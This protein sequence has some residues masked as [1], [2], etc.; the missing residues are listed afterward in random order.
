METN[1]EGIRDRLLSRL[2]QPANLAEYGSQVAALLAKNEKGLRRETWG[3][4]ATWIFAVLLGTAF[5]LG[6]GRFLGT[7]KAPIAA[8]MGTWACFFLIAAAV[9]L[10]KHFINRARVELLKE[11]K[12]LQLQ[13]LQLQASVAGQAPE[14]K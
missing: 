7:S 10:L 9:E 1:N 2:P 4:S 11:I 6:S 12:Q 3:S 13:V 8:F 5:L 14:A